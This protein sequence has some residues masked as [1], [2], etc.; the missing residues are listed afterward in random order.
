MIALLLITSLA[1]NVLLI[2]QFSSPAVVDG[3]FKLKLEDTSAVPIVQDEHND[4]NLDKPSPAV[5][6][7]RVDHNSV[8]LHEPPPSVATV[9]V[10]KNNN[11]NLQ[12]PPDSNNARDKKD[13]S[14]FIPFAVLGFPKTGTSTLLRWLPSHPAIDMLPHED[15]S[16]I[17]LIP[18][19]TD[20]SRF[21]V[22]RK[23]KGVNVTFPTLVW[24]RDA[25][26]DSPEMTDPLKG[27]KC[28]ACAEF[29]K[30]YENLNRHFP[31]TPVIIGLRH[32]VL[33]F[34][35]MWNFRT[36]KGMYFPEKDPP[37]HPNDMAMADPP[38][39]QTMI[40][41]LA[42]AEHHAH[43]AKAGLT[44]MSPAEMELLGT[45]FKYSYVDING[46]HVKAATA[47]E[48]GIRNPVFLYE[49]S[50]LKNDK[51]KF[52]RDILGAVGVDTSF[53]M[54]PIFQ[55]KP[56]TNNPEFFTKGP[57]PEEIEKVKKYSI[58]I[59]DEENSIVHEQL[60]IIAKNS[61]SWI[62]TYLI[63]APNVEF[64]E[65]F[66][67]MVEEWNVDPCVDRRGS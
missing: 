54:P 41:W 40:P 61:S 5:T 66:I 16:L 13:L 4:A 30:S 59:C 53:A 33:W 26:R 43:L 3:I 38:R 11:V 57:L 46:N 39:G 14:D 31:R 58:D 28:P 36:A 27:L 22:K 48:E 62:T 23:N 21:T 63:K 9:R 55:V 15:F 19:D 24:N 60:M 42:R 49:I 18:H 8:K 52:H 45:S 34:E 1:L 32:P 29:K 44:P 7:V 56:G 20:L 47:V 65:G 67:N 64:S 50:Q 12:P 37:L 51:K 17:K 2:K 35:S 10:E 6:T 25:L